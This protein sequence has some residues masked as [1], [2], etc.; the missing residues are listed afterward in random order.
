M[1]SCKS[2]LKSQSLNRSSSPTNSDLQHK[3]EQNGVNS[4]A[5]GHL[6]QNK[7]K[8]KSLGKSDNG[9]VSLRPFHK[10]KSF[11]KKHQPKPDECA[12]NCEESPSRGPLSSLVRRNS[13]RAALLKQTHRSSDAQLLDNRAGRAK[14]EVIQEH[15]LLAR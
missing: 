15:E 13:A 10:Q 6:F 3:A 5:D 14:S 2:K 8:Q 12:L 11:S 4:S 9:K 7:C 1:A